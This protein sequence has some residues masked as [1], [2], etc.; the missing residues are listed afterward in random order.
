[1]VPTNIVNQVYNVAAYGAI[2]GDGI[3]NTAP[4]QEALSAA[5]QDGGELYFPPGIWEFSESLNITST[6]DG[7]SLSNIHRI[8]GSGWRSELRYMGSDGAITKQDWLQGL[9]LQDFRL[10]GNEDAK[11]GIYFSAVGEES[12]SHSQVTI[13]NLYINRFKN[14]Y[15]I[16]MRQP[17]SIRIIGNRIFDTKEGIY[18]VRTIG[19]EIRSNWIRRWSNCGI[20]IGKLET[21]SAS[22]NNAIVSNIIDEPYYSSDENRAAIWLESA[23][24]NKVDGNY[25]EGLGKSISSE[26]ENKGVVHGI[27]IKGTVLSQS[28]T[29]TGNF[30]SGN[31]RLEVKDVNNDPQAGYS[32]YIENI[33]SKTLVSGNHLGNFI[34]WDEGHYTSFMMQFAGGVEGQSATR[35]GWMQDNDGVTQYH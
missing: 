18:C 14:G 31:N 9:K 19:S 17:Y 1:M 29:I 6:P 33:G 15:G 12:P 20:R 22:V 13:E 34:I 28:N 35:R 23:T 3:D 25:F 24:S 4:I 16:Y 10:E 32:I 8:R 2:S 26:T 5:L 11:A 27:M 21:V 7:H 30:F